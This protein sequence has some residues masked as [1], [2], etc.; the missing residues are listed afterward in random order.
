MAKT[1]INKTEIN[2]TLNNVMA[3]LGMVA[4]RN[5]NP[6]E[7][8]TVKG[9]NNG[10]GYYA[11]TKDDSNTAKRRCECYIV[12]SKLVVWCGSATPIYTA[13]ETLGYKYS[14]SGSQHRYSIPL[15]DIDTLKGLSVKQGETPKKAVKKVRGVS[16][17]GEKKT[18]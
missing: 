14:V 9:G 10:I 16:K 13:L 12:G 4:T 8:E 18:A 6:D 1:E 11:I 7:V 3:A 2:A 5:V 15:D 17:K